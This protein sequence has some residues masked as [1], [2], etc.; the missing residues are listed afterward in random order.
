M[1]NRFRIKLIVSVFVL[2]TLFAGGTAQAQVLPPQPTCTLGQA[3]STNPNITQP[4]CN[5]LLFLYRT[6]DGPNWFINTGWSAIDTGGVTDPCDW[7]HIL[8]NEGLIT[9]IEFFAA[10][11]RG[12]NLT[13][14]IPAQLGNLPHLTWLDLGGLNNLTGEI[15]TNLANLDNLQVLWLDG[16]NEARAAGQP[17]NNLSGE[18]P[19]ELGN[20][21][22]LQGLILSD[23][24]FTGEIPTELANITTL[25]AIELDGNELSGSIPTELTNLPDLLSLNV[26]ENNLSGELP[27]GIGNLTNLEFLRLD[28]NQLSGEIPA[29]AGNLTNLRFVELDDNQF[30]GEIPPE[31][32][33]LTSLVA[34]TLR[35]NGCLTASVATR[36]FLDLIPESDHEEALGVGCDFASRFVDVE[37]GAF[38]E[39]AVEWAASNGITTGT[40]PTTFSPAQTVTRAELATFLWRYAGEP[41]GFTHPFTDVT[42]GSFFEDAVA[43]LA[44]SGITT[45][46]SPTTF[47]PNQAVNR[48]QMATFLWRFAGEP[49]GFS[50]PFVD[51]ESPSFYES[52]V[53]WMSA[54]GITTGTSP[55]TFSPEAELN[56]AQ[57]VTFL[58]RFDN[59]NP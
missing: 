32:S 18:I 25:R 54:N 6:T 52:G 42:P 35:N 20:L 37:P 17:S 46:T 26:G 2:V 55:T 58:F 21:P 8:C 49:T 43:W 51:V 33:N 59:L 13:G 23:N 39:A 48:A 29:E 22:R 34:L 53:A 16:D 5:A 9:G 12:N 3:V 56:R 57:V 41:T 19:V 36:N 47:S 44:Q 38:Y 24:A 4:E 28:E 30:S 10:G 40:S 31:I 45:G 14:Q 15:P 11:G 27:S 1:T 7:Y 50:H